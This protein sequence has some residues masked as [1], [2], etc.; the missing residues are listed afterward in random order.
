MTSDEAIEAARP[1]VDSFM[2]RRGFELRGKEADV[3]IGYVC[4][5][6][7]PILLSHER[8]QTRLAHLDAIVNRDTADRLE[9]ELET[10]KA[11]AW[12]EGVEE[13]TEHWTQTA[14]NPN[15][16]GPVDPPRNPYR[17]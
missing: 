11:D 4:E 1:F 7:K 8:E 15:A 12:D 13:A 16:N 3:L 10:A 14:Y 5:A 17:D 6:V 9:Q 2:K